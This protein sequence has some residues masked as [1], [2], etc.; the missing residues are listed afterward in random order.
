MDRAA[1]IDG[2]SRRL[3]HRPGGT[4]P[5]LLLPPTTR[6]AL[7]EAECVR[8]FVERLGALSVTASVVATP[9]AA[10]AE[11]ERLLSDHSWDSI[12][13]SE[14]LMWPAIARYRTDDLPHAAFGLSEAR[15][16]VAET[17]TVVVVNRGE[18]RRGYSLLPAAVGFFVRASAVTQ[19]LGGV[20]RSM[21]EE[22]TTGPAACV[23]FISGPSTT[24]DIAGIRVAGVH[25]PREV[26]V[27]VISERDSA[28][29]NAEG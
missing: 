6:Q 27:W 18:E 23:S 20:L 15:W 29:D 7:G 1:F 10:H 25:G 28:G 16:G 17:G 21:A 26:Y 12:A 3:A 14:H 9:A 24:A 11:V 4:P 5:P 22:E 19:S 13:C 2:L 8:L